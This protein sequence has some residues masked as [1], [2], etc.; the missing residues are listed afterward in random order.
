[1]GHLKRDGGV[2]LVAVGL[3]YNTTL[4]FVVAYAQV[5]LGTYAFP[6]FFLGL[7]IEPEPSHISKPLLAI[8]IHLYTFNSATATK[9]GFGHMGT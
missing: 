6:I 8:L 9:I 5:V 1:M 2:G 7:D 4:A 3:L